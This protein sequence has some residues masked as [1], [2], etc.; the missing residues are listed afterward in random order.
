MKKVKLVI[1]V[2]LGLFLSY[3]VG[4]PLYRGGNRIIY[5]QASNVSSTCS[6]SL[7]ICSGSD[8]I[9]KS[10]G[11]KPSPVPYLVEKAF[12]FGGSLFLYQKDVEKTQIT[13]V[14][15]LMRWVLVNVD[16]TSSK[17]N[18]HYFPPSLQ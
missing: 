15:F 8:T 6:S 9:F 14:P 11:V 2:L 18:V 12:N 10:K 3:E 7:L 17:V 1:L 4:Y 13:N 5:V 16:S